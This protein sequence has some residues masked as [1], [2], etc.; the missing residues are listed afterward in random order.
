ML[1]LILEISLEDIFIMNEFPFS[2]IHY[3]YYF[4]LRMSGSCGHHQFSFLITLPIYLHLRLVSQQKLSSRKITNFFIGTVE[5]NPS[6]DKYLHLINCF[7]M[8]WNS[9]SYS[10]LITVREPLIT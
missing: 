10:E 3:F 7:K 6:C 9:Q 4:V 5:L 8:V 1:I 2:C